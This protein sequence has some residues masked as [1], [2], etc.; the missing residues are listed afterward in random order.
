MRWRREKPISRKGNE[1]GVNEVSWIDG[2]ATCQHSA[3]HRW[4]IRADRNQPFHLTG[5]NAVHIIMKKKKKK[6]KGTHRQIYNRHAINWIPFP[7]CFKSH[8]KKRNIPTHSQKVP[9]FYK[10]IIINS[11][12]HRGLMTT[13]TYIAPASLYLFIF[14][15]LA[16]AGSLKVVPWNTQWP[17]ISPIDHQCCFASV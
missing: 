6:E 1:I 15:F 16:L 10:H 17:T 9:L 12:N 13:Y 4:C 11:R 5:A 8:K 14:L 3:T 2:W 7:Q